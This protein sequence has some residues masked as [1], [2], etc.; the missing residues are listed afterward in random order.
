M[1]KLDFFA[2]KPAI[3][4][5][6]GLIRVVL[7]RVIH[8]TFTSDD[9]KFLKDKTNELWRKYSGFKDA[10]IVKKDIQGFLL[11]RNYQFDLSGNVKEAAINVQRVNY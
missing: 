3:Y 11:T 1:Y 10:R 5:K 4:R 8:K 6:G 9:E 2:Y 7:N